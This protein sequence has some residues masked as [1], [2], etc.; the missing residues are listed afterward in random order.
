M[1]FWNHKTHPNVNLGGITDTLPVYDAGMYRADF[2]G[3]KMASAVHVETMVGQTEVRGAGN[4]ESIGL[5]DIHKYKMQCTSDLDGHI[6]L[7]WTLPSFS[8]LLLHGSSLHSRMSESSLQGGAVL[9]TVEETRTVLAQSKVLGIPVAIVAYVHLGRDD[10]G[11]TIDHHEKLAGKAFVGVRMI[12]NFD[13][14]DASLCWPQVRLVV[15]YL[16]DL[17]RR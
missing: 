13:K 15:L 4:G 14:A 7:V 10:A 12:L 9:D 17:R 8:D 3:L 16:S 2:G 5:N 1:Q 11:A 6:F